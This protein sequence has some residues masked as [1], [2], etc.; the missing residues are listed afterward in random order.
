M[1]HHNKKPS[2]QRLTL[3]FSFRARRPASQIRP[4]R[5][6]PWY[7]TTL[8]SENIISKAKLDHTGVHRPTVEHRESI[9][10]NDPWITVADDKRMFYCCYYYYFMFTFASIRTEHG[11]SGARRGG[12]GRN[13]KFSKYT[14]IRHN[15]LISYWS[16]V[17]L[18]KISWDICLE[19]NYTMKIT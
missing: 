4:S 14:I 17:R 7:T 10:W 1:Q 12:R 15:E 6:H 18:T 16:L 13:S 19:K 2:E 3:R 8:P 11:N 5:S 9:L